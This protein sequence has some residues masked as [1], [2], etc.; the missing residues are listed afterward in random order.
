MEVTAKEC[1]KNFKISSPTKFTNSSKI[2]E[3]CSKSIFYSLKTNPE[4]EFRICL[5]VEYFFYLFGNSYEKP[6]L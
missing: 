3:L 4:D 1:I 5:N 6:H 2:A